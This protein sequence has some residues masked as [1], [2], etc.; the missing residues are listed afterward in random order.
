MHGPLHIT[1]ALL[2]CVASSLVRVVFVQR[3][4]QCPPLHPDASHV[5]SV[6]KRAVFC[7]FG[8]FNVTSSFIRSVN[9]EVLCEARAVKY[10]CAF[11][12]TA[13]PQ[14]VPDRLHFVA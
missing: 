13:T 9:V 3:T 1:L 4:R 11:W 10:A 6:P 7:C 12:Y 5:T 8:A 2:A 14:R